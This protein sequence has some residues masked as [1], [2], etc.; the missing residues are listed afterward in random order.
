MN[1]DFRLLNKI[2]FL[3]SYFNKYVFSSF[4]KNHLALKINIEKCLY[5]LLEE[6]IRARLNNG[7]IRIKHIKEILVNISLIDYYLSELYENKLIVKDLK[8]V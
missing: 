6:S 8:R 7:N 1:D 4:P 2:K 5:N 3:L